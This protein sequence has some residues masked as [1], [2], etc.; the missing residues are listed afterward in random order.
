MSEAESSTPEPATFDIQASH[1]ARE[2]KYSAPFIGCRYDPTGRYVFAA[3]MDFTIQRWDLQDD[4]HTTFAAHESWL[5]GIGFSPDGQQLVSAGYDGKLCF[6]ETAASPAEGQAVA[7]T[8]EFSAHEGW[9]RWLAVHPDGKL[10]ATAGN[11]L[12]V[13]LWSAETGELVQTLEGHAKHIYSLLFHPG[14]ELLLSGDLQGVVNQWELASGKLVRSLDAKLLYTYHGGQQVDYGGVR[15]MALSTDGKRLACGGLHKATN[16]FAGVQEPLVLVFDWETGEQIRTHEATEVPRGIVWR[17][18]YEPDGTLV[19]GI[20]GQAGF[21]TFWKEEK[22]EVHK[23][24]LP[25]TILDLDQHPSEFAVVT[26]H[27]DNHVRITRMT[28]KA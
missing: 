20:G 9:V 22:T 26:A 6:W 5:R 15:C 7:P 8:R 3:S 25:N 12:K 17:L 10:I 16:P 11:D 23:L 27:H 13:K 14:G 1:V 21:L 4:S 24:A 19:G 18:V 2:W 28:A